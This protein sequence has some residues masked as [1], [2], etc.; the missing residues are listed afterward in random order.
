MHNNILSQKLF[1]NIH[2]KRWILDNDGRLGESFLTFEFVNIYSSFRTGAE[3]TLIIGASEGLF[4]PLFQMFFVMFGQF[5]AWNRN[6]T[7]F[8]VKGFR[9]EQIKVM[10]NSKKTSFDWCD[11]FDVS[12]VEISQSVVINWPY[13]EIKEYP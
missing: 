13:A 5:F 3:F 10:S 2:L 6:K 8:A 9:L 7:M 11:F 1:L 4:A 12:L